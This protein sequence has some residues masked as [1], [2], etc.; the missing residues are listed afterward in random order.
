MTDIKEKL[1]ELVE[2][3][4]DE[5]S[6]DEQYAQ[7]K[8]R[9]Q[10][11]TFVPDSYPEP[12]SESNLKYDNPALEL[13]REKYEWEDG[14]VP[15]DKT[16]CYGGYP[17]Y[18]PGDDAVDTISAHEPILEI[19]AG[20]GYLSFLLESA[21]VTVEPTDAKPTD[22]EEFPEDFWEKI[23]T[24][25]YNQV[26]LPRTGARSV[27]PYVEESSESQQPSIPWTEVQIADH[28][29]ISERES[30]T[31]VLSC[32]PPAL[33]W[34]EEMLSLI[35]PGQ[36]FIY[37]GEWYPGCDATPHFF[38]T[39]TEWELLDTFNVYNW[40]STHAHGYVFKKT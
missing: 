9:L 6:L 29:I 1:Q 3:D 30:S 18:I 17:E 8:H 4:L 36:K 34:T 7:V 35:T 38:E 11:D 15:T 39:L 21:G 12:P 37:I 16:G 20:D 32:H 40:K 22:V 31:T 24:G 13:F 25:E 26:A 19:G 14:W 28:T 33:E 2:S 27:D 5:M 23:G 10:F